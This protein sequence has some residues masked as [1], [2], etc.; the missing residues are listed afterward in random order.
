MIRCL[1]LLTLVGACGRHAPPPAPAPVGNHTPAAPRRYPA[2]LYAGLFAQGAH[3]R[4][5]VDTLYEYY[6]TQDPRADRYGMVRETGRHEMTCTVVEVEALPNAIASVVEC[7]D[8]SGVPVGGGDPAGT[9]LANESGLW[10]VD[11][12]V[13]AR[14]RPPVPGDELMA[15]SPMVRHSEDDGVILD[16]VDSYDGTWCWSIAYSEGDDGSFSLCFKDGAI[17]AGSSMWAGGSSR[18]ANYHL[19]K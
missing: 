18:E 2:T 15:S 14:T 12:L 16:V 8:D 5:E 9:F 4:Y 3:Y 6:D 17:V 13:D 1:A 7:D 19:V 10:R 11:S